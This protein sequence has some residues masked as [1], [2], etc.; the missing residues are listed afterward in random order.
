MQPWQEWC[1]SGHYATQPSCCPVASPAAA[2]RTLPRPQA[3]AQPRLLC[4]AEKKRG[5]AI[6]DQMALRGSIRQQYQQVG[7][8]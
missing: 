4:C 3:S 5:Q 7:K 6:P 1:R 2:S 8:Q